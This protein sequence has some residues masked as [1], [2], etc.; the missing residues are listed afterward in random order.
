MW[1]SKKALRCVR[2]GSGSAIDAYDALFDRHNVAVARLDAGPYLQDSWRNVIPYIVKTADFALLVEPEFANDPDGFVLLGMIVASGKPVVV[3]SERERGGSSGPEGD[4]VSSIATLWLRKP[5]IAT[6]SKLLD[7]FLVNLRRPVGA[8]GNDTNASSASLREKVNLLAELDKIRAAPATAGVRF[9]T[10]VKDTLTSHMVQFQAVGSHGEADN[11]VDFVGW[12]DDV[13]GKFSN[14]ILV[15]LK[16]L[17]GRT[18]ADQERLKAD[19]ERLDHALRR[20][21]A[22]LGIVIYLSL[23][24]QRI[25]ASAIELPSILIF[26]AEDFVTALVTGRLAKEISKR[27]IHATVR[28]SYGHR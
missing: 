14:P 26:S 2:F 12:F 17:A 22:Q 4:P 7:R 5:D 27:Q 6:N 28:A 19:T 9:E 1:T 24:G 13:D 21:D 25:A 8:N 16:V 23:T 20:S 18:K 11:G 15:Q 3:I 10:W